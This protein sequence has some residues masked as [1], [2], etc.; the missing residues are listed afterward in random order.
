MHNEDSEGAA[1]EL[2]R[3]R[4][5]S[6]RVPTAM[7]LQWPQDHPRAESERWLFGVGPRSQSM[8]LQRWIHRAPSP[9]KPVHSPIVDTESN[10]A[11]GE[12]LGVSFA[13]GSYC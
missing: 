4:L 1:A 8:R 10:K 5:R 13:S 12:G 6:V 7:I 11:N 9:G 2:G 3:R